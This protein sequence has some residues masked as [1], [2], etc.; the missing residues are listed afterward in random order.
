MAW[1]MAAIVALLSGCGEPA[2]GYTL[3]Q[4]MFEVEMAKFRLE[5]ALRVPGE[6]GPI[7]ESA[8]DI[9]RWMRDPSLERYLEGGTFPGD[10]ERFDRLM[11]DFEAALA[12]LTAA[13]RAG[14]MER[15]RA[16]YAPLLAA[17]ASCHNVFRPGL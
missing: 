9:E 11:A 7:L 8:G 3:R 5:S 12:E 4:S 1:R 6:F 16:G 13:A 10:R 14:D 15:A 17:C 2:P